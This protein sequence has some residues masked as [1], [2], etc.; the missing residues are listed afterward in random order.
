VRTNYVWITHPH[1][2]KG[3]ICVLQKGVLA[4]CAFSHRRK[5]YYTHTHTH[6]KITLQP[7]V[8]IVVV[9]APYVLY[10]AG[11]DQKIK[12]QRVHTQTYSLT[13]PEFAG[14]MI[15]RQVP[16]GLLLLLYIL[17]TRIIC[18]SRILYTI[19][20]RQVLLP[21]YTVYVRRRHKSSAQL[22]SGRNYG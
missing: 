21:R 13:I 17:Y 22:T 8:V 18:S 14:P 12:T 20:G 7:L 1:N 19:S 5:P 4:P 6:D 16:K 2:N 11:N 10:A 15:R 9:V 3:A